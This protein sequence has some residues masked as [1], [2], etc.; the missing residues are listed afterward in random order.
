M[1]AA[2]D[3]VKA[4]CASAYSSP[5][6][7]WLLGDSYHPGGAEL[8]GRLVRALEVGPGATVLDVASGPGTSALQAARE[9]GCRVVG[10]D[11]SEESVASAGR[12]AADAGLDDRVRFLHG[13]AEAIP[14][15][16]ASAVGVLCECSLCLFPDK[17]MA[18]AEFA[19]V[20]RPGGRLALSDVTAAAELPA[21]LRSLTAWMACLA[22]ARPLEGIAELLEEA[23]FAIV[24][25]ERHDA[26]LDA[27]LDRVEGRL[28]VA[29]IAGNLLPSEIGRGTDRWLGLVAA[30]REAVRDGLLGY[31]VVVAARR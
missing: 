12:A 5:A 23:G 1:T 8:T 26:A 19:R 15:P 30:A 9:A 6:A 16:D 3:V 21:E 11:L 7:R 13:D 18:A 2:P 4:C 22:A 14:L 24:R 10:I 31:G 28:R 20:L 17:E 27:L 29:R 25:T